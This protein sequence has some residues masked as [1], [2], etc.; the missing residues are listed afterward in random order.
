MWSSRMS[1]FLTNVFVLRAHGIGSEQSGRRSVWWCGKE[2][3]SPEQTGFPPDERK[4]QMCL[5]VSENE[6]DLAVRFLC[7]SLIPSEVLLCFIKSGLYL[8]RLQGHFSWF[9]ALLFLFWSIKVALWSSEDHFWCCSWSPFW[10][11]W[12]SS[13]V[14]RLY[15]VF[16]ENDVW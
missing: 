11:K 15:T 14:I 9:F 16:L 2:W 3:K 4:P 8:S 6:R 7:L 5:S 10:E 12:F 1:V 13:L